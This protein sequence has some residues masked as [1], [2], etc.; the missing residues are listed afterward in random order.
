MPDRPASPPADRKPAVSGDRIGSAPGPADTSRDRQA[1]PPP[2]RER[3]SADGARRVN[4]QD[5]KPVAGQPDTA[6]PVAASGRV[7]PSGPV[8]ASP[9]AASPA[10]SEPTAAKDPAAKDVKP[11]GGTAAT[12]VRVVPGISR[13]H[14]GDC[15]LIRFMADDD[16]E[17]M[18]LQ[19][20]TAEGYVA[21]KACKPG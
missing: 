17:V 1:T 2:D 8:A 10:E 12:S 14:K 6:Q 3:D 5:Q 15:I 9:A 4:G 7:K 19:A 18:S 16:L 13:Y 20:A 21:C 11:D